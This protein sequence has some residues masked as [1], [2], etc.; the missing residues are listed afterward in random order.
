MG[1]TTV[2]CRNKFTLKDFEFLAEVL[3]PGKK[4]KKFFEQIVG[5]PEIRDK[6]LD[7]KKIFSAIKD[8]HNNIFISTYLYFYVMVRNALLASQLDDRELSDYVAFLLAQTSLGSL[9]LP[10]NPDH[11]K[12]PV[13]YFTDIH[14]KLVDSNDTEKFYL[15]TQ[16]ADYALYLTGM[17]SELIEKRQQHK[18]A[19]GVEYYESMGAMHFNQASNHSIADSLSLGNLYY[20]LSDLFKDIRLSLNDMAKSHLFLHESQDLKRV[21]NLLKDIEGIGE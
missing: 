21:K 2:D 18:G 4:E 9:N 16:A 15:Q 20:Q 7:H 13:M 8:W 12:T 17:F 14:Q 5:D 19:P 3:S 11:P 10:T 1:L 6:I